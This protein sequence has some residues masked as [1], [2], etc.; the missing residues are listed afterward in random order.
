MTDPKRL[1]VNLFEMNTVG[2]ITHGMWRQPGNQREHYKDIGFW[3][4][5]AQLVESGGFDSIFIADVLGAYDVYKGTADIALREGI[6]IPNNDPLLLIP[7]M[8]AVT[9][10]VGFGVT[11]S[12]SY[13]PPFTFARRMST[14]DHLTDGRVGWNVVTSYLPNAARNFGLEEQIPHDTRYEIANEYLDVLYKLWEGSWDDDAV[15]IDREGSV[16]TD[17][18]RV[19]PINHAGQHFKVAGP[20]LSEPS[21]QRT[22]VIFQAT[23]S[24]AGIDLAGRH[25]EVIFTGGRAPGAVAK[26]ISAIRDANERN[27]RRRDDTKF[28][29][30]AAVIVGRNDAEVTEKLDR[31]RRFTSIEGKFVHMSIPFE[32]AAHPQD[33]SVREA[34]TREGKQDVIDAGGMPL[35]ITVGQLA[36]SV[37]ESWDQQ[38]FVAGT[39]TVVA[40]EIERWLDAEGIDGINLRQY[41]SFETARDFVEL[42]VPELR[43]RGR[44]R[45]AYADGE[46]LR[47]RLFGEGPRL[48]ERHYGARYRGGKNL[49]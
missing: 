4:E 2:H 25:A 19:R 34:L 45:D 16:Y 35:D 6:Q 17:P 30:Q 7:A 27:G 8:A 11:F 44:V 46:T 3:I 14:L 36:K 12:T 42:V 40:D 21:L 29:V 38:F 9:K 47:E 48:P 41:H 20:H 37:N 49:D 5:L 23:A 28:L 22:P 15:L 39:P 18:A 33:I 31:Y 24:P 32:P 10:H 26:N 13:E 1:I 43:K